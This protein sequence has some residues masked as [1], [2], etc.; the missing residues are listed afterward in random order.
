MFSFYP[1]KNLGAWGDGGLISFNL[2]KYLKDAKS[3]RNHGATKDI[4]MK[5][6]A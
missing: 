5:K 1:T 4:I 2:K 3:L 6:L